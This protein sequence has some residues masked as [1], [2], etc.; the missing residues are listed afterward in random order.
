MIN[1]PRLGDLVVLRRPHLVLADVGDDDG[2]AVGRLPDVVD[3]VRRAEPAIVGQVLDVAHRRTAGE[4]ADARDPGIV[5]RRLRPAAASR[6][7]TVRQVAGD[8]DVGAHVLVQLGRVDVDVDLLGVRRVRA[9]AC[10]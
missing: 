7:S 10:R 2:A 6:C 4:L 1:V 5:L 3:D 9:P 8:G